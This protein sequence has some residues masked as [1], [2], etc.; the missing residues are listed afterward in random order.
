MPYFDL[1]VNK[2][3]VFSGLLTDQDFEN[4]TLFNNT[5]TLQIGAGSGLESFRGKMNYFMLKTGWDVTYGKL[6]N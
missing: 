3:L 5:H 6:L 2:T 1:V 4:K